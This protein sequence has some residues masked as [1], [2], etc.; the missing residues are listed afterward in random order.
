MIPMSEDEVL[1]LLIAGAL[2]APIWLFFLARMFMVRPLYRSGWLATLSLATIVIAG[3]VLYL[4]LKTLAAHDVRD[5]GRYVAFYMVMGAAWVGVM[6]LTFPWLG[7]S[8]RDDIAE[9]NNGAAA[10]MFGGAVL[11]ATLAF[12][13]ANIGDGPGWWCVVFAATLSSAS[14]LAAWGILEKIARVSDSV[15]VDRD[16]ASGLRAAALLAMLGLLFGRGAA[17]D[18][19]SAS[20]TVVEFAAAWPAIPLLAAGLL[21]ERRLRPAARGSFGNFALHGIGPAALY[22]VAALAGLAAVGPPS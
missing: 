18:W 22:V 2:A 14:W 19:T 5:D 15:T 11:G 7:L 10:T 21:V 20:Q 16:A 17:G 9:R 12:A 1:V 3:A 13:Q 8:A 6:V 4:V